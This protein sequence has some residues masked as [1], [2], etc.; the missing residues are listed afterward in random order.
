MQRLYLPIMPS[1]TQPGN[2]KFTV[3]IRLP[4]PRGE[5][6]DPPPVEWNT[7]KDQALWDVLSRPSKGNDIDWK[8]LAESFDV[9]L[10]FLLQQAAWLY[11]R[12][13]SQVRAQMRKVGTTHSNTASPAPGSVHSSTAL[14]QP[15]KAGGPSSST[16][17]PSR[18]ASQS[19]EAPP[20]RAPMPR[21]TSSGTTVQ[22][23]KG[24]R[25]A[26]HPKTP[27]QE[28]KEPKWESHAPRPS[29][30]KHEQ[31][32]ASTAVQRSP[33]LE[34]E[35]LT[36][37]SSESNSDDE[38]EAATRRRGLGFK[39]FGRFS[40]HRPGLR[41]DDD[42]DDDESP[43]FL[44][45]SRG[46]GSVSHGT[47]RH[48]LSATLRTEQE[49][50]SGPQRRATGVHRTLGKSTTTESSAS[51][52]SSGAPVISSHTQR[53]N[54]VHHPSPRR[55]ADLARMSPRRSNVSGRDI[56]DGTP[57]MGSSFS[58][59]DDTS[60]TQSM[61]EEALLSN[62]QHGGMASRMSTIS[63][64]LRSRYLP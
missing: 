18:L 59:L 7:A 5:F 48:D 27:T 36:S 9:T 14:G 2:T 10:Q 53:R 31:K 32:P 56:S 13:L 33:A 6:S 15:V 25:E 1:P 63:Q 57:S 29:T 39:R 54:H 35:D 3:L 21:R 42:D 17:M 23:V 64:A 47:S 61:L 41:D 19:K 43:A 8:A 46:T 16:R 12:Q 38:V 11:D 30:S 22:Q 45:L 37:S 58:D 55:A 34:E 62:M 28:S 44:P 52:V 50:I 24:P 40:T 4:F 51:S 20:L 26:L 60:V 49:G